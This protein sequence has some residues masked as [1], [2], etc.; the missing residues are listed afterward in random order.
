[1]PIEVNTVYEVVSTEKRLRVLDTDPAKNEAIVIHMGVRL[2]RPQSTEL[3]DLQSKLSY[4]VIIPVYA[5][6]LAPVDS[7]RKVQAEYR[8]KMMAVIQ[9]VVDQGP[10][11]IANGKFW[12]SVVG[13]AETANLS[14]NCVYGALTRYY[15]GGCCK[16]ALTPQWS[17]RGRHRSDAGDATSDYR[18]TKQKGC[19][20]LAASD[21]HKIKKGAERFYKDDA[22]W[23]SAYREFLQGS[24][25]SHI[26][27][28]RSGR[29]VKRALSA[30]KTPSLWQFYRI[31]R[32]HLKTI[33]RLIAK[34]GN[35][36]FNLTGRGK[37]GSQA[38]RAL[39]P[40]RVAEIDWTHTDVVAV[41]RRNR[42]SIGRLVVYAI[43]DR[44]SGMI[45][46]VYLTMST[47]SWEEAARAILICMEDKREVCARANFHLEKPED[48]DVANGVWHLISDKGEIDSWKSTPITNG[49]GITLEHTIRRRPDGKGTVEAVMK[50]INYMLFRRLLGATT[51]IRKRCEDDARV[52]ASYDFDQLNALLHAFVIYWNKRIRRRQPLAPGMVEDNVI[53]VPNH[54]WKWGKDNGCLRAAD[55]ENAK[56]QLLPWAQASVTEYGFI[57]KGLRYLI[58]DVDAG[59]PDGIEANEWMAKA[60]QN[61][62]KI[63]LG[64]DLNTVSYVWLRHA[65]RG[66]APVM[67]KCPL[68]PGQEGF[69]DLSWEEWRLHRAAEKQTLK[70]YQQGELRAAQENFAAIAIRL[71][72]EAE[73]QTRAA[74][75]GLSQ[76]D[77]KANIRANREAEKAE[78]TSID[79]PSA[80]PVS[81]N[82][83]PMSYFNDEAWPE[84]HLAE[85]KRP[86]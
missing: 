42:T 11:A 51:G 29:E 27:I 54:V 21:I 4:N 38:A 77:Q 70:A 9:P 41:R 75:S 2:A 76:T 84:D 59:S 44:Y 50:I 71:A 33:G 57:L 36:G 46:S 58:P 47:G 68:A 72:A 28:D 35:R 5:P 64:V 69:A 66:K 16:A 56:L 20:A 1:M 6:A 24:Y 83:P 14:A 55:I 37:P 32:R 39:L 19:F 22:T 81:T 73:P 23:D 60:R 79:S 53:P 62:W 78:K 8:D 10:R 17:N 25:L 3:S 67:T 80:K 18:P 85:E 15:Q 43:V 7:A 12:R 48:W 86:A 52:K 26:E 45:L 31:G 82:R 65:P 63:Q 34:N 74:R 49:L 40:G 61:R 13:A 30:D